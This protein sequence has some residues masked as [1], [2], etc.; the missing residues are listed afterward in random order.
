MLTRR[1]EEIVCEG[2]ATRASHSPS[3]FVVV[4]VVVTVAQIRTHKTTDTCVYFSGDMAFCFRIN[5]LLE[6]E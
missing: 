3:I 1:A 2:E 4:V 6:Y 5:R